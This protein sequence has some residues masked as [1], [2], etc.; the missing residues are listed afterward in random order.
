VHGLG[1]EDPFVFDL[2][3]GK[4]DD[5]YWDEILQKSGSASEVKDREKEQNHMMLSKPESK[6]K[7]SDNN[8]SDSN[9]SRALSQISSADSGFSR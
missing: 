4:M 5:S 8:I 7:Q 9:K 6:S 1:N 2:A 3:S